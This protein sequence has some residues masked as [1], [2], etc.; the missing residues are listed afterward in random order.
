MLVF[1]E[2]LIESAMIVAIVVVAAILVSAIVGLLEE[3][4]AQ[5]DAARRQ[6][7]AEVYRHRRA[8]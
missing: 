3:R 5:K 6:K 1:E 7:L 2:V 8:Y 4:G